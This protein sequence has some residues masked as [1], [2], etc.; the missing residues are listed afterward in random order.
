MKIFRPE[1]IIRPNIAE[2]T[3]YSSARIEY[4][5]KDAIFFDA[6]ENP[7]NR[8][9][10][11]YP[12]PLHTDLK[13]K[14]SGLKG[15][16]VDQ[17]FVGNGSDEGIDLLIRAFCIPGNDQIV[18]PEPSYGMYEVCASVNDVRVIKV[19][20]NSDFNLDPD[21]ILHVVNNHTKLIFICSPNNPTGNSFA[22]K[23]IL[24]L[25]KKFHGIVVIDE[26]YVDFAP[27]NGFL[28]HLPE[29]P[30]LVILQTF[31]KA[32]GMAGIR[33]GF[34]FADKQVIRI[35][36][37]IKYPYNVSGLTQ[38]TALEMLERTSEKDMWV[39][40]I[41]NQKASLQKALNQFK[42]VRKI[43]PS[44][45]NFFLVKVDDPL[46]IYNFLESEKLIIRN[47]S[48]MPL[49]EGCLRITVGTEVENK[50]LI[51][52]LTEYQEVIST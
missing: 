10:N 21:R 41:L 50:M 46:A 5:G 43:Y 32:W 31:S 3:P 30:N 37:K 12:D 22:E 23:D 4:S 11:R 33:L 19:L 18:L 7:F 28:K 45:A 40:S 16:E 42:F 29:F 35:L 38:N 47:R 27:H 48:K 51:N 52:K 15:V 9:Y 8:P 26:A 24:Y 39:R 20:L 44:D 6:N 36:N 49:C 1:D 2:L 25:L 13:E 14:V 34:A 17:I